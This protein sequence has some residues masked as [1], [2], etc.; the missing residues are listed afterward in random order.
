MDWYQ[1]HKKLVV[2]ALYL[3]LCYRSCDYIFAIV[4][5]YVVL[6]CPVPIG[7]VIDCLVAWK[8]V[9]GIA[10]CIA[11]LCLESDFVVL[12]KI[13]FWRMMQR[14]MI[15]TQYWE[16][17]RFLKKDCVGDLKSYNV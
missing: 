12:L 10:L 8:P 6:Y 4:I 15:M 2:T 1:D 7:C 17:S 14:V 3:K 9:V 13:R 16:I 11:S 5:D